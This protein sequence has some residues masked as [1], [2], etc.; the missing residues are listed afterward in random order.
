V[1][2]EDAAGRTWEILAAGPSDTQRLHIDTPGFYLIRVITATG[3]SAQRVVV[4]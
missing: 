2:I 1:I 3:R 4:Q